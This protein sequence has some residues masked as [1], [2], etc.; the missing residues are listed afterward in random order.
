MERWLCDLNEMDDLLKT[1]E[2]VD[3]FLGAPELVNIGVVFCS[4]Q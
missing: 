2:V 4:T 3:V 1:G